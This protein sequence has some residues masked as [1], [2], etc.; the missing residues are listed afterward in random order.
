MNDAATLYEEKP[1][2]LK[3]REFQTLTE[4][5][6]EKNLIVVSTGVESARTPGDIG[7]PAGLARAVTERRG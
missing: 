7:A 2:A 3:L 5:A 6:K 1:S 4:I